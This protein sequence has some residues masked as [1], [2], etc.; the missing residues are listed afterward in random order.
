MPQRRYL[1]V[2]DDES[3]LV[4]VFAYDATDPEILHIFA[5][6]T[7]SPEEAIDAFFEGPDDTSWND[8]HARYETYTATHG[9]FWHWIR[10]G[11]VVMIITCFRL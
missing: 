4:F 11:E 2:P 9:L 1:R 6:H 3:G 10:Q 5:R 8:T 7:T